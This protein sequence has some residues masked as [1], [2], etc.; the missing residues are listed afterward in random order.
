MRWRLDECAYHGRLPN[1]PG[2]VGLW[3]AEGEL[4]KAKAR[5]G[6]GAT[7]HVVA[8]LGEAQRLVRSLIKSLVPRTSPP[9]E[10][11]SGPRVAEGALP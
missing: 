5:I 8:T 7:T 1:V 6:G 3:N 9:G 4:D 11:D 2:V 10:P